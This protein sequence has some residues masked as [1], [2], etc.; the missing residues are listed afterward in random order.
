MFW[1]LG[2]GERA[3]GGDHRLREEAGAESACP[4]GPARPT[5]T[6]AE[7]Q[8]GL[9]SPGRGAGGDGCPRLLEQLC[10]EVTLSAWRASAGSAEG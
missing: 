5:D 4:W 9:Q 2:E 1:S 10:T 3:R 8:D 6:G 7:R